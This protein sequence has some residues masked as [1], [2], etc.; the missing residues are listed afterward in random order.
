MNIL[1]ENL[2]VVGPIF[3]YNINGITVSVSFSDLTSFTQCPVLRVHHAELS[4]GALIFTAVYHN[5]HSTS[6]TEGREDGKIQVM[7]GG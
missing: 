2:D 4:C 6:Q 5:I 7:F 3:K 1:C